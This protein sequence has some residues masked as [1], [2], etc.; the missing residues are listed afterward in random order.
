[1]EMGAYGYGLSG[2][3]PCLNCRALPAPSLSLSSAVLD[4]GNVVGE[5]Q[6]VTNA[7]AITNVGTATGRYSVSARHLP[8]SIIV[9]PQAGELPPG[10]QQCV[11][12]S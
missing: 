5:H 3:D 8:D 4:F 6:T 7:V 10:Q 2:D 1:M 11:A 12:V 9:A